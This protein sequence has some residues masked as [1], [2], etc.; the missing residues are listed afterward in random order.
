MT[1]PRIERGKKSIRGTHDA[2]RRGLRSGYR[3]RRTYEDNRQTSAN[4]AAR[5]NIHS[6]F[7]LSVQVTYQRNEPSAWLSVRR[8]TLVIDQVRRTKTQPIAAPA[9]R[10]S[11]DSASAGRQLRPKHLRS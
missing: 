4:S 8:I 3:Q 5:R 2:R 11:S 9:R 10:A 1:L 7:S 6:R